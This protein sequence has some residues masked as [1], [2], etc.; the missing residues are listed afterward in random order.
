MRKIILASHG[1]LAK[2]MKMSAEMI[3]GKQDNLYA[4]SMCGTM[5]PQDVLEEVKRILEGDEKSEA[6]VIT[7]LPGGSVNNAL[8]VLLQDERYFLVSG[9]NIMLGL[10]IVL[11]DESVGVNEILENAIEDAKKTILNVRKMLEAQR[12]EGETFY[13]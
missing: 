8:S 12:V 7:D 9:M 3:V 6:I 5:G 4:V 13:D 11:S 1:E 2:G 10:G